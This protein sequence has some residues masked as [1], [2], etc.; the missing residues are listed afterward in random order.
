MR[1]RKGSND[2]YLLADIDH[3]RNILHATVSPGPNASEIVYCAYLENRHSSNLLDQIIRLRSLQ[4]VRGEE[5]DLKNY[6]K[7]TVPDQ[8]RATGVE[9]PVDD[10]DEVEAVLFDPSFEKHKI[11]I[12]TYGKARPAAG[13]TKLRLKFVVFATLRSSEVESWKILGS[14]RLP[15]DDHFYSDIYQDDGFRRLLT[16]PAFFKE[17]M[18][19]IPI[20]NKV[21]RTLNF[22]KLDVLKIYND[23]RAVN[24][25]VAMASA[26]ADVRFSK[27]MSAIAQTLAE[28]SPRTDPKL[29]EIV[30]KGVGFGVGKPKLMQ[31]SDQQMIEPDSIEKTDA[32]MGEFS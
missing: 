28:S 26:S 13:E 5:L 8:I 18:F 9:V 3:F 15:D 29:Q 1:I 10:D 14:F 12:V 23:R 22:F 21:E 32:T 4:T 17:G 7:T 31:V 25:A 24:F 19:I 27:M 16:G 20:L 2:P 11:A 30:S 6:F